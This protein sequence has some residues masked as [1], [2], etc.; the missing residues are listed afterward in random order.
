MNDNPLLDFS[1]LPRFADIR[2]E[3]VAPAITELLAKAN[4]A[5]DQVSADTTPAEWDQV[6]V[7]LDDASEHLGARGA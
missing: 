3:H 6:V 1:G 4:A 2:A 5:L 7:P